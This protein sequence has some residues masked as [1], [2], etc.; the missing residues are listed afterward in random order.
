MHFHENAQ[1]GLTIKS[2]IDIM[3]YTRKTDRC[4]ELDKYLNLNLFCQK[5]IFVNQTVIFSFAIIFVNVIA[6]RICKQL[7]PPINYDM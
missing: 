2:Y 6:V 5:Q 1:K 3:S 4:S 7:L